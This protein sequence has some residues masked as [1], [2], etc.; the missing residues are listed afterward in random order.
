MTATTPLQLHIP[1]MACQGCA[2]AITQAVRRYDPDSQLEADLERKTVW[3]R[4]SAAE[5][6]VAEAI[7]NAGYS[8]I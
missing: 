4:T 5:G 8:V 6:T 1:D 3:L 2:D 7:R